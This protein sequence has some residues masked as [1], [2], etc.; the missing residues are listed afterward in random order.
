MIRRP[1]RST[2]FPYTTLFRSDPISNRRSYGWKP[3]RS[4][5]SVCVPGRMGTSVSGTVPTGCPST[6][7]LP[8]GIALTDRCPSSMRRAPV[9]GGGAAFVP[10]RG[11]AARLTRGGLGDGGGSG[12]EATGE[13]ARGAGAGAGGG[14]GAIAIGRPMRLWLAGAA[15]GGDR[16][17]HGPPGPSASTTAA[18]AAGRRPPG[19]GSGA[20]TPVTNREAGARGG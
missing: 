20:E 18:A 6:Y 12:V 15:R 16:A 7:T 2:L 4:T 17:R 14:A 19:R 5:R 8:Q 11:G 9:A 3:A 1:P 13:G 10:P